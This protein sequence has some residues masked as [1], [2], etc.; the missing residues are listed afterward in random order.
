MSN[1]STNNGIRLLSSNPCTPSLVRAHT[2]TAC[3][4]FK[5]TVEL[6]SVNYT[7]STYD[8]ISY[9]STYTLTSLERSLMI[10]SLRNAVLPNE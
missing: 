9:Y 4:E 1:L 6:S 7:Y 3:S 5:R 8:S 2:S 10:F